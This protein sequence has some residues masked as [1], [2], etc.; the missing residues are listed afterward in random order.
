MIDKLFGNVN[1][2]EKGLDASW[3]KNQVITNNISN[4]DTPGFKSSSVSFESM[5]K[6]ALAGDSFAAK[7]T[8]DGHIDFKS[9]SLEAA[10]TTNTGTSNGLDGNNVDIDFENAEL[11]KNTIYYNTLVEQVTSEYRKLSSAINKVE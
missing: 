6:S 11:A 3:L 1:M 9:Q 2:L 10:V 4:V 8:R 7:K 5:F